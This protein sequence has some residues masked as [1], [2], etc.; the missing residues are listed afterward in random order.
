MACDDDIGSSVKADALEAAI[1][2]ICV[3]DGWQDGKRVTSGNIGEAVV[4]PTSSTTYRMIEMAASP[5]D[6]IS[7][8]GIS[9]GDTVR[10]VAFADKDDKL[11]YRTPRD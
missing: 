2:D 11:L 7:C 10:A 6:V 5:G 3:L 9:Q 8:I 4:H 1:G